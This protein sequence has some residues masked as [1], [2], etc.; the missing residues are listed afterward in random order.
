MFFNGIFYNT[1]L[2]KAVSMNK[3]FR[4]FALTFV[5]LTVTTMVAQATATVQFG[6]PV[7]FS[8]SGA[9]TD[10]LTLIFGV[11]SGKGTIP[12]STYD[13]DTNPA[14]GPWL[15][16]GNPPAGPGG[17]F[18]NLAF[19]DIPSR[20]EA[21]AGLYGTTGPINTESGFTGIT[22]KD[23]RGYTSPSQVDSF[24]IILY[25]T[26]NPSHVKSKIITLTWPNITSYCTACSLYQTTDNGVTWFG[27]ADM[28]AVNV[29]V[30]PTKTDNYR[31]YLII[32]TG[33]TV[34]TGV[35]QGE[36]NSSAPKSFAL[37]QNYPNPFNPS[38]RI[39]Y[40]LK[41]A[42]HVTLNI[43]NIL[44]QTVETLVDE[45][46]EAGD[47]FKVFDASKLSSGIYFYTINAGGFKATKKMT[48]MK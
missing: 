43:V 33:A 18:F 25:G 36:M 28:R 11:N 45:K 10:T 34:I 31:E 3:I 2:R 5:L 14:L 19:Y 21:G 13:F 9:A 12:A 20:S 38:T 44:G 17:Y 41:T 30:T 22:P 24:G 6:I 8:G 40:S 42:S 46:Q 4:F 32:K 48:L 7:L 15:E 16:D 29:Y 47:H 39:E 23:F 26:S 27:V 37:G 1:K 35:E